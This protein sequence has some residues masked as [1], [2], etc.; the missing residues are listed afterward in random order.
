[1]SKVTLPSI[2]RSLR[3][4]TAAEVKAMYQAIADVVNGGLTADNFTEHL[5]IPN[6]M[7]QE[8]RAWTAVHLWREAW[9]G[10]AGDEIAFALPAVLA[11][12]SLKVGAWSVVGLFLSDSV[13]VPYTRL[14]PAD[15]TASTIELR[16]RVSH[17]AAATVLDSG[18]LARDPTNGFHQLN[19]T[20]AEAEVVPGAVLSVRPAVLTLPAGA[21]RLCAI[22]A[23]VWL[24]TDHLP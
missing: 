16:R 11:G 14:A 8:P 4:V 24:R 9:S 3:S 23:T 10:A 22:G 15:L 13:A 12:S 17:G 5:R 1:M 2:L 6:A 21:N 19:R 20:L 7:K 18:S